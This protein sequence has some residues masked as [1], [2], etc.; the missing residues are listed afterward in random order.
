MSLTNWTCWTL[1]TSSQRTPRAAATTT[2][3]PGPRRCVQRAEIQWLDSVETMLDPIRLMF[4]V[5][6]KVLFKGKVNTTT[7]YN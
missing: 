2:T 1:K 3:D 5:Y 4:A 6:D 7:M